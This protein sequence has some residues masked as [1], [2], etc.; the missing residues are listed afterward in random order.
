MNRII[1]AAALVGLTLGTAHATTISWTNTWDPS[2][3]TGNESLGTSIFAGT[4]GTIVARVTL[5]GAIGSG[6]LIAFNNGA[7]GSI[8]RLTVGVSG[9]KWSIDG[10][11]WSTNPTVTWVDG[12]APAVT[13]GTYVLGL[14]VTR[15]G[16]NAVSIT[17][18]VN[19]KDAATL[20]GTMASGPIDHVLWG[21]AYAGGDG[22][23]VNYG[24]KGDGATVSYDDLYYIAGDALTADEIKDGV[25]AVPEPTALAL[26]ALGVAGL[27]LRRR[28][29]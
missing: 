25:I 5:G 20:S 29:A 11:N 26:L 28:A 18:T 6:D 22:S 27:A 4:S 17:L 8:N 2:S 9:G 10:F 1:L 19:G 12:E 3:A 13:A 21:Q 23:G 7:S 16:S 15:D 14:S 24:Y